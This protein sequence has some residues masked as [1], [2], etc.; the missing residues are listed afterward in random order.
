MPREKLFTVSIKD[1][2]IQTFRAGGKGGANQNKVSSGVRV[3]HSPSG[4]RGESRE[5]RHQLQNKKKAFKRMIETD[6]FKRWHRLEV[7]KKIGELEAWLSEQMKP[8]NL[9]VEYYDPGES[10]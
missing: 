2:V 9:I 1:C 7:A 3:I 8:E 4:A 5:E 10:K 6:E